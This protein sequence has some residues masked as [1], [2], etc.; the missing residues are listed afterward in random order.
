[1]GPESTIH[2]LCE[3]GVKIFKALSSLFEEITKAEACLVT[4]SLV[5]VA[6]TTAVES[7]F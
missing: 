5:F 3:T 4:A 1:M 7:P 2:A 6:M